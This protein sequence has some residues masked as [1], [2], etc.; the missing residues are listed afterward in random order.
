[1]L[2]LFVQATGQDGD[3]EGEND[4]LGFHVVSPISE[5]TGTVTPGGY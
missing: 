2:H 4:G 3:S 1:M 5:L